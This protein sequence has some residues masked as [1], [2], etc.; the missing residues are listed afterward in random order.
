[1]NE[2]GA[3]L[4]YR[5]FC[6]W[7]HGWAWWDDLLKP[8]DLIGPKG[9]PRNYSILVGSNIEEE[10]LRN[11]RY[12]NVHAGGL[13]FSYVLNQY[14]KRN[15]HALLA[16]ISHSAEVERMNVIDSQ[17]LDYLETLRN[18]FENIYVSIYSLDK[19]DNIEREILRRRLTPF[20]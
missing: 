2:I 19:S 8:E 16:F 20:P 1:M 11:N 10:V 9:H 15:E 13:P 4:R 18:K 17:Y 5:P 12:F 6:D 3:N 7:V 14:V